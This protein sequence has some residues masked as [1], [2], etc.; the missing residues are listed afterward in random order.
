MQFGLIGKTLKHSYSVEIHNMIA[1]YDYRLLEISESELPDFFK[2]RE[3]SGINVTIPYK[4][5]IFPFLNELSETVRYT[6]AVNTVLNRN[7]RLIGD[8]TDFYGMLSL[9]KHSGI[10]LKGKKVLILGTGGTSKTARAVAQ[11]LDAAEII[12]VSRTKKEDSITYCEAIRNYSDAQII[13]NTTPLGMFPNSD[14]L[15][16]GVDIFTELDG[17]IDVIYNPIRTNLVLDAQEKGILAEGGLY[18]L[19]AQ[20]VYASSLFLDAKPDESLI[21]LTYRKIKNEKGNIVLIGMPSS[22][23][24]TLGKMLSKALNKDFY[25][26]DAEIVKKTGLSIP[27]IFQKYGEAEFRHVEKLVVSELSK[28]SGAVIATGGGAVLNSQNVRSLKQNGVFIFLNRPFEL[29]TPTADRPLSKSRDA[30]KKLFDERFPIYKNVADIE[31]QADKS[32]EL[33]LDEIKKELI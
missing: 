5:K 23:K 3:F 15:P 16:I 13:I 4:E 26:S 25:D 12:F 9:I 27:E 33:I 2:K 29:L 18:M 1:D 31:I 32:P 22:G 17:V 30:L 21:D 6:G 20:A 28:K 10:T 19:V 24:T 7:G 14:G 8:N 11:H